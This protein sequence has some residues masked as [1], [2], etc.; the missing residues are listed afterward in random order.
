ME[1]Y[2]YFRCLD[3]EAT[4]IAISPCGEFHNRCIR[5]ESEWIMEIEKKEYFQRSGLRPSKKRSKAPKMGQDLPPY[6]SEELRRK[7]LV[8]LIKCC[9]LRAYLRKEVLGLEEA[10]VI[11]IDEDRIYICNRN[12]PSFYVHYGTDEFIETTVNV[13]CHLMEMKRSRG[14]TQDLLRGGLRH[15]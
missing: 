8:D 14:G 13:L 10:Y 5:C 1:K 3:C 7:K 12:N 4:F 2:G 6:F 15:K 9:I 11:D